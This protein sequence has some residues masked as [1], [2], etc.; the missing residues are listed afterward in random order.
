MKKKLLI[1]GLILTALCGIHVFTTKAD[2]VG[3]ISPF[4]Y[5][6]TSTTAIGP[7]NAS[8]TLSLPALA[9]QNCVGTNASGTFGAGT[10]TGG[11]GGGSTTTVNGLSNASNTFTFL[12]AGGLLVTPGSTST[13]TLTQSSQGFVTNLNG[14]FAING[15]TFKYIGGNNYPLIQNCYTQAQLNSFFGAAVASGISVVR[16]WAFNSDSSNSSSTC[17]D[18]N[19]LQS[20]NTTMGYVTSTYTNMD[21]VLATAKAYG[22]RLILDL[23]DQYGGNPTTN[24]CQYVG[25]NNTINSLSNN[26]STCDTFHTT[27]T[28]IQNYEAFVSTIVNRTSTITGLAYKSDPTIFSYELINE[29]RYTADNGADTNQ[30]TASSSRIIAMA[31]WYATTSAYIYSQDPNHLI[32]TGSDNQFYDY[33]ANDPYHNGSYYGTDFNI[34]QSLPHIGYF[35]MHEYPYGNSPGFGL[36]AIGQ[37]ATNNTGVTSTTPSLAG[38][39]AQMQQYINVA[40]ADGKPVTIGEYGVDKRNT[41]TTDP[42]VAYPRSTNFQNMT[43]LWFGDGGDGFTIWHFTN[44]FD[45]N[46]YNVYPG[47]VH[48][49]GNANGNANDND[50]LLIQDLPSWNSV[51]GLGNYVYMNTTGQL[52]LKPYSDSGS[53]N[54]FSFQNVSGTQIFGVDTSGG[55]VNV[56]NNVAVNF[57]DGASGNDQIKAGTDGTYIL[58][59]SGGHSIKIA[60]ASGQTAGFYN[61]GFGSLWTTDYSGNTTQGGSITQGTVTSSIPV[62]NSSGLFTAFAGS[63]TS[64]TNCLTGVTLSATGTLTSTN[65]SCG[66]AGSGVA[67]TTPFVNN[68]IVWDNG[69]KLSTASTTLTASGT[70]NLYQGQALNINGTTLAAGSTTANT[71]FF[72]GAGNTSSTGSNNIAIGSGDLSG[73]T[74]GHDNYIIGYQAGNSITSGFGNVV[75]GSQDAQSFTGNAATAYG[76]GAGASLQSGADNTEVGYQALNSDQS[77]GNNSAFGS[78]S[79]HDTTGGANTCLGRQAGQ[80]QQSGNNNVFIGFNAG[81]NG[82]T[83]WSGSGNVYIG[84]AAGYN[85]TTSNNLYINNVQQSSGAND[86]KYSLVYGQ[87]PNNGGALA[88]TSTGAFYDTLHQGAQLQNV[89]TTACG[90]NPSISGS[91]NSGVV[92]LGTGG[93]TSCT[94]KFASAWNTAPVC[95]AGDSSSTDSSEINSVSTSQVVISFPLSIAGGSAYYICYGNPN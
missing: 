49:G 62:A 1:A 7:R 45:D 53:P 23:T 56:A 25:W 30:N 94:V 19:Y 11:A 36:T 74:S 92:T 78:A 41:T 51:L 31:N 34:D 80:T 28:T 89:T 43:N 59:A 38:F 65:T 75:I 27:T 29:G 85:A 70:I 93:I 91:D 63:N 12:G 61:S 35:D 40:H 48:S 73:L 14:A 8:A 58:Q 69:G 82:G 95:I 4:E 10:C 2:S 20:N 79:C 42:F 76:S 32:G 86:N 50:S 22:I 84:Q 67:S 60:L 54:S 15:A 9:S 21:K 52:V 55:N 26:T 37:Q 83:D 87:F 81:Q 16:T 18:F 6:G 46:N 77:G 5:T 24:K 13:I 90:T 66:G 33:F 88:N 44:L 17:G 3:V 71:Y 64:S 39:T 57:A 72:A 68:G 47:A